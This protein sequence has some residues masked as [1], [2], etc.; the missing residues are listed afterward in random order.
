MGMHVTSENFENQVKKADR[1]VLL[2][3]FATWCGPCQ[4]L[5]PV[6]EELEESRDDFL[7]GKVNVDEESA[8]ARQFSITAVP[9]LL[10]FKDGVEVKRTAGF[11]P[12]EDL[13]R[14]IDEV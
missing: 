7:V 14:F 1:P 9:T 10:L 5:T 12:R 3:F 11:L 8:L 4:M 6:I 13:E 2:D